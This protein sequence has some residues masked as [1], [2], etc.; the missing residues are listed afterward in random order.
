MKIRSDT[1]LGQ[2]VVDIRIINCSCHYFTTKLSLPWD[3]KI[4]DACN[5]PRYGRVYD[6]KYYLIV[7]SH[8]NWIIMNF[9][10]DGTYDL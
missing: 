2:V 1:K 5:Q 3:S 9:T 10:D 4:K 8:N 6:C 7:E